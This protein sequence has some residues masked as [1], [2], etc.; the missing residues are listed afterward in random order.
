MTLWEYWEKEGTEEKRTKARAKQKPSLSEPSLIEFPVRR[1]RTR[2]YL[3]AQGRNPAT[4]RQGSFQDSRDLGVNWQKYRVRRASSLSRL[5]RGRRRGHHSIWG[6]QCTE[7][8]SLVPPF[9]YS[10][11]DGLAA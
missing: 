9:R 11:A 1:S 7:V 2:V 10:L 8:A 5:S 3:V 6:L 4:D